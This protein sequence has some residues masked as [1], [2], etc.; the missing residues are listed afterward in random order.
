MSASA[1][2]HHPEGGASASEHEHLPCQEAFELL[3]HEGAVLNVRFNATGTYCMSC[4]KV[5][6]V[7]QGLEE[8]RRG[9]GRS[10]AVCLPL[11]PGRCAARAWGRRGGSAVS[12]VLGA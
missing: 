8:G 5:G 12:A 7:P 6:A 9:E 4:G 11:L 1:G 3:G 2:A 10:F